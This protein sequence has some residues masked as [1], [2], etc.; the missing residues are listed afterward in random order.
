MLAT[1]TELKAYPDVLEVRDLCAVLG[2]SAKTAYTLLRS[3][4]IAYIRIGRVYK[5]PK[6]SVRRYLDSSAK[7]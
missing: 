7:N 6:K 5:I 2:I 1:R 4:G 3:G